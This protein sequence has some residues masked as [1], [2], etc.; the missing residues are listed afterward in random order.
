VGSLRIQKRD[1]QGNWSDVATEGTALGQ[2]NSHYGSIRLAVDSSGNLYVAEL[3]Y[4]YIGNDRIQ[5]R[6]AQGNWYGIAT[7][8]SAV[9]QVVSPSAFAVDIA[10]D[11]YVG[12]G[13][14][15][16][17]GSH[18]RHF[19]LRHFIPAAVVQ[20]RNCVLNQHDAEVP[21]ACLVDGS[22]RAVRE[23]A[24]TED[25]RGDVPLAQVRLK[26]C[27]VERTPSGFVDHHLVFG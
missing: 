6:D 26:A 14:Y 15:H 24:A 8:G 25:E 22:P 13:Y 16:F 11:L 19:N 3:N 2:V 9:G 21:L 27:L 20:A 5:K 18:P 17:V 10:G 4:G 12:E 7:S 23:V 1:A